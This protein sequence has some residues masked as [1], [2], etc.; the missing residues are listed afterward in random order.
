MAARLYV[1][2]F[3]FVNTKFDP[4]LETVLTAV[5]HSSRLSRRIQ[6][7]AEPFTHLTN[8]QVDITSTRNVVL[9]NAWGNIVRINTRHLLF[10]VL[11]WHI[12][13]YRNLLEPRPGKLYPRQKSS[14]Q[15]TSLAYIPYWAFKVRKN[16]LS[17]APV[18]TSVC[19]QVSAHKSLG[20]F[21]SSTVGEFR[22]KLLGYSNFGPSDP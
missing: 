6:I 4:F 15:L 11:C 21:F 20:S 10:A 14:V 13:I 3:P 9:I 18:W 17:G 1:V 12:K 22:Q 5:F 16:A 8:L 19:G 7:T 2:C